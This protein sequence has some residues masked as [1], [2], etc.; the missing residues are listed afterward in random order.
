MGFWAR[1]VILSNE[2]ES[3]YRSA[4]APHHRLNEAYEGLE[5]ILAK[6]PERGRRMG[7]NAKDPWIY[8]Q[9]SDPV[10]KTPAIAIIY[11]Y[12]LDQVEV[13]SLRVISF[14]T[15]P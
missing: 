14:A 2:A 13:H 11:N 7:T 9:G 3:S 1:T 10:A 5:W 15:S 6:K 12:T 4:I 8:V